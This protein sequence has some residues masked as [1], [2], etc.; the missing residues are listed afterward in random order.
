M[1]ECGAQAQNELQR[2]AIDATK[3]SHDLEQEMDAFEKKKLEDIKASYLQ[4]LRL[5]YSHSAALSYFCIA[6][7]MILPCNMLS[8]QYSAKKLVYEQVSKYS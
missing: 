1:F 7:K 2:A 6:L 5:S 4:M 3:A 8:L